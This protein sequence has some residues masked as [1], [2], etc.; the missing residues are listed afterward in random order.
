MERRTTRATKRASALKV[1]VGTANACSP[2]QISWDASSG[3]APWTIM[4]AP[5]N[6][7]PVVISVPDASGSS[8]SYNW[9]VPNFSKTTDAFVAVSDSTGAVSGVASQ[10]SIGT[11][12]TNCAGPATGL[13]FVWFP[14]EEAALPSQCDNWGITWQEDNGNNGI[15]GDVTFTFLPENGTPLTVSTS[16]GKTTSKGGSFNF[17]IP[18]DSGTK[19]AAIANDGGQAGTGG[20]GDLYSVTSGKSTSCSA[21]NSIG[22][23]LPAAQLTASVNPSSVTTTKSSTP[24]KSTSANSGSKGAG[25]STAPQFTQGSAAAEGSTKHSS[26]GAAVGG[27]FAAL[28]VLGLI[29]GLVWYLRRRSAREENPFEKSA[30]QQNGISPWRWS[31]SPYEQPVTN[32]RASK[33]L[34]KASSIVPVKGFTVLGDRSVQ[35]ADNSFSSSVKGPYTSTH[36]R[37]TSSISSPVLYQQQ[38]Q[39][40]TFRNVVP[41]ESLF[42]PPKPLN[43]EECNYKQSP[44]YFEG[45]GR[46]GQNAGIGT[47]DTMTKQDSA[48]QYSTSSPQDAQ[49]AH[50]Q[51]SYQP[52][53]TMY[54]TQNQVGRLWQDQTTPTHEVQP[55]SDQPFVTHEVMMQTL[56]QSNYR[57]QSHHSDE[58]LP[59]L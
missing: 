42:P 11:S 4:I 35:D 17:E 9:I 18:W 7:T 30:E 5:I 57:R 56:P 44:P 54:T 59:Y 1:Q 3:K 26:A 2:M 46:P 22:N 31:S 8:A 33:W 49:F 14:T 28:A 58:G 12:Q 32:S 21:A 36:A 23:G 55:G 29:L 6:E 48:S 10:V 25:S 19:F 51:G 45:T 16:S 34:D 43:N 38:T 53:P 39:G 24:A 40:T 37:K 13:D 47:Y 41:D 52:M 20:V 15:K 50:N 27:T